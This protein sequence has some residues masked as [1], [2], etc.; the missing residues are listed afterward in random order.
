MKNL[1][2][3]NFNIS[4]NNLLGVLSFFLEAAKVLWY[5]LMSNK[6]LE[7]SAL[8]AA[9]FEKKTPFIENNLV[10]ARMVKVT[11]GFFFSIF[12]NIEFFAIFFY[13][14]KL[15]EFTLYK[16]KKI[17]ISLS[18]NGKFSPGK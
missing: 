12:F 15:V 5:I 17:S 3:E 13:I 14:A 8:Q 9:D 7:L 2:F 16:Q 11:I 1:I 4:E 10:S 18:K 6:F